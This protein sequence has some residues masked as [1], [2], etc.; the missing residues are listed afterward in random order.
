MGLQNWFSRVLMSTWFREISIIDIE[1]LPSD[2]GSIIV[3]WHP[4]GLFDN[5]LTRGLLPGKQVT[6]DGVIDDEDELFAIATE[7]ASGA[8]VVVF[9][10]GD[11]HDSPKSKQVTGAH[12]Y[13]P[14]SSEFTRCL[15]RS[16]TDLTGTFPQNTD[17]SS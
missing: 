15:K 1:N 11:S 14:R 16:E 7:V 2:R 8:N 4:G 13:R 5:M 9:P 10:E 12:S 17:P 3:S 6:F